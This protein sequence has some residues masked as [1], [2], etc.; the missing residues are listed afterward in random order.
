MKIKVEYTKNEVKEIVKAHIV[1]EFP[2]DAEK[3]DVNVWESF[4]DYKVDFTE[5]VEPEQEKEGA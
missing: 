5:K 3:Y 4:G 2:I 1:K